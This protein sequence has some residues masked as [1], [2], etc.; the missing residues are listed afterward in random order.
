LYCG[1]ATTGWDPVTGLG[2]PDFGLLKNILT[3][4][5][6]PLPALLG[7]LV[8]ALLNLK[9]QLLVNLKLL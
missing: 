8:G 1:Q 5:N 4:Y 6:P 9:L 2:T 3:T 7:S